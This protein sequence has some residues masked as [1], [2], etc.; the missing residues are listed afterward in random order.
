[1][2]L[3]CG[4]VA[5]IHH[6]HIGEFRCGEAG[7]LVASGKL[8]ANRNM[9]QSV[10]GPGVAG[11]KSLVLSHAHGR[12]GAQAPTGGHMHKNIPGCDGHAV[13]KR[14]PVLDHGQR[15]QGHVIARQKLRRQV[16]GAVGSY[17]HLHVFPSPFS[18]IPSPL[19]V[20]L[21]FPPCQRDNLAKLPGAWYSEDAVMRRRF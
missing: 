12:R 17:F 3:S 5:G 20:Y 19:L 1:M 13:C 16:A 9:N 6:T 10:A 14:L 7:V 15:S 4:Q 18:K 11:K 2:P 8:P 21:V